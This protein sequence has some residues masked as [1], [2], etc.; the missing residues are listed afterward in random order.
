M[1]V[2]GLDQALQR[3]GYAIYKDN[4][5]V[6]YGY[7][8]VPA[9]YPI[10]QRL[11]EIWKHLNELYNQYDFNL[12]AFEDVQQQF[13]VETFKRLCYVQ[14]SILLWCYY[15]DVKYEILTPSH[16]RSVIGKGWGKKRE[17]QKEYAVN[18]VRQ[19]FNIECNSDTADAIC[20]GWAAT[21]E[22]SK[23][24]KESAF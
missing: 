13:N 21:Q 6:D 17:E 12:L 2:L 8:D 20:I 23:D 5:L 9:N 18:W 24:T 10:E 3:S 16:W 11:G 22:R 4:N 19:K 7:F 14:S 15:N 1:I